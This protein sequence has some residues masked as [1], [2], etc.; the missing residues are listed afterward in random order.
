[1]PKPKKFVLTQESYF[2]PL[3]PFLSVSQ[4]N[5]YIRSPDLYYR[6]YIK[7]TVPRKV[8]TSMKLGLCVDA[9]LTSG[10][11]EIAFQ[12]KVLKKENLEMY[13]LQKEIKEE[14]LLPPDLF[15][16]AQVL[17]Q[18]IMAQP[19]WTLGKTQFQLPLSAFIEKTPVCG[20]LDRI[21][22]TGKRGSPLYTISDLKITSDM[23]IA[24]SKKWLHNCREMG[25]LRQ[26][27]MYRFLTARK[28]RK[29]EK[30]IPFFHIV[31]AISP[32]DVVTLKLFKLPSRLIDEAFLQITEAIK[33]INNKEWTIPPLTWDDAYDYNKEE[34]DDSL[35]RLVTENGK[36]NQAGF[37]PSRSKLSH[38]IK[39]QSTG[40]VLSL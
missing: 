16:K 40:G 23:K 1:M 5:D 14:Y 18:T 38:G 12:P 27:A 7:K 15:H 6:K 10:N 28:Y 36:R 22:L 31:A 35:D 3:R 25:Y 33:K 8:T 17:A 26:A 29:L 2:D 32:D 24:S 9:L 30:D 37:E 34:W 20:L 11:K 39:A 19:F 4:I 21:D 13:E